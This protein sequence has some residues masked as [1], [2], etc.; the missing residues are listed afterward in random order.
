MWSALTRTLCSSDILNDEQ[1]Q[2]VRHVL[3]RRQG[4]T[5]PLVIYGPFG[6]GKTET[7]AQATMLLLTHSPKATVLICTHSNRCAS[8]R[9]CYRLVHLAYV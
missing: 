7:L 6:T 4:Y 3:T 2:I 1:L 5:A 8:C 9:G